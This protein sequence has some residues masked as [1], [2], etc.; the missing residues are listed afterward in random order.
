M[1]LL[2]ACATRTELHAVLPAGTGIPDQGAAAHEVFPKSPLTLSGREVLAVCTGVGPVATA[3]VLGRALARRPKISGVVQLGV[4]GSFDLEAAPMG[5]TLCVIR[6][7]WPEYG[8]AGADGVA[9]RGIGLPMAI[10][11][12][13]PVHETLGA[14]PDAA[15][16]AMGLALPAAFGRA[17]SLTVAG[18]TGTMERAALLHARHGALLE[19]ME[20]FAAALA[21]RL[22][23]T[24]FL[25]I[26][27]VSNLVGSRRS[28]HWDLK[29]A[30]AGLR[31]ALARLLGSAP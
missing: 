4:A 10:C 15:A 17:A 14:D 30:L 3:A 27:T 28:G 7:T 18:V 12:D 5:A 11:P 16:A 9:P 29:G 8:L 26:R 31:P 20:G 6:E 19:N 22:A 13:G 24:P 25:Q 2:L 1:T 21:C 23:E